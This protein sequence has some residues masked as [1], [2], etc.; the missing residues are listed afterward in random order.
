MAGRTPGGSEGPD[1]QTSE[2]QLAGLF[3]EARGQCHRSVPNVPSAPLAVTKRP[4]TGRNGPWTFLSGP[5][6]EPMPGLTPGPSGALTVIV[7]TDRDPPPRLSHTRTTPSL[8]LGRDQRLGTEASTFCSLFARS[9]WQG[10]T[11]SEGVLDD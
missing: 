8:C 7:S 10:L 4:V 5:L 1:G 6:I 3:P 9:T 11:H 2:I